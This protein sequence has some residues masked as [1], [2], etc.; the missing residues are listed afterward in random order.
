MLPLGNT[1]NFYGE[2]L[3][4]SVSRIN[5]FRPVKFITGAPYNGQASLY[6]IPSS[7]STAVCVGDLVKLAGNARSP[8]GVP[9]VARAGATD[10]VVGVVVGI[11]FSGVGD[12]AN[13]PPVTNLDVPVY[14]AAST[15]RYVMVADDPTVVFEAQ[16]TGTLAT[17]DIGLNASPDVT[18]GSTVTGASGMSIDGATKATTATLPLKLVGFPSRPDNNIGDSF[19]SAY[20]QLNNHQYKGST[21]TA[22]V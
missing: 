5:G 14:R 12:V 21:G 16:Y 22:G 9:T 2:L 11:P 1:L 13:V 20:V 3:M 8:T 6:F 19:V 17:A 15:D 10:A 7:D 18:A 4:A